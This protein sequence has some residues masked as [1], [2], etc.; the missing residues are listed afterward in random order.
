MSSFWCRRAC[1]A[2][3]APALLI[4]WMVSWAHAAPGDIDTAFGSNG[5]TRI[6]AN[7]S[8]SESFKSALVVEPNGSI[9]MAGACDVTP[10]GAS[11][12]T[13]SVCLARVLIDGAPD[14]TFGSNGLAMGP[15]GVSDRAVVDLARQSDGKF[16]VASICE[17]LTGYYFCARRLTSAGMVDNTFGINGA[18]NLVR[19]TGSDQAFVSTVRA[20]R[21]G[22]LLLVGRCRFGDDSRICLLRLLAN[23]QPDASHGSDGYITV[24]LRPTVQ[25]LYNAHLFNFLPNGKL[26]YASLCDLTTGLHHCI[27]QLTTEATLDPTFNATGVLPGLALKKVEAGDQSSLTTA[28][29]RGDGRAM[30]AS[31][32]NRTSPTQGPPEICLIA[33]TADGRIDEGFGTVGE[34]R[35]ASTAAGGMLVAS[36]LL[37]SPDGRILLSGRCGAAIQNWLPCVNRHDADGALDASFTSTLLSSLPAPDPEAGG[38]AIQATGKVVLGGACK[39]DL[40][41]FCITR[42]FG[43]PQDYA[44]CSAD[45]DGD[46]AVTANDSLLFSRAALGFTGAALTDNIAFASSAQRNT[47]PKIR[48]YLFNHCGMP[49]AP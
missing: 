6:S 27:A 33:F 3:T 9:V 4:A 12:R 17:D 45:L 24:S 43:G 13:L 37:P 46:G 25:G 14:P 28:A 15:T 44:R 23:G 10:A 26:Q 39:G 30:L 7:V 48:D 20:N 11:A 36:Q 1:R 2:S 19:P 34:R 21:D 31:S 47:W 41:G 16:V 42:I 22:T 5:L 49:V 35:I 8:A 18:V 38:L 32:C 40:R 29:L